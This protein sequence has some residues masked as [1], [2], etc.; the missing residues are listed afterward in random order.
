MPL[1]DVPRGTSFT[2][3]EFN[4]LPRNPD[5][6]LAPLTLEQAD[7]LRKAI[8]LDA[9]AASS[10]TAPAAATQLLGISA[11]HR[12]IDSA[13]A[14]S[15]LSDE[16]K[17]A[18]RSAL[19]IYREQFVPRFKTGL[20]IDILGNTRKNVPR[21][22][23]DNVV[24]KV[25]SNESGVSQ[26]MA[27]FKGDPQANAS[28]K[29]G[30][31]DLFERQL[32]Q[33]PESAQ[34]WLTRH[35]KVFDDLEAQGVDV[36]SGLEQ[37][38]RRFVQQQEN[39]AALASLQTQFGAKNAGELVDTMLQSSA[40]LSRGLKAMDDTGRRAFAQEISDRAMTLVETGNYAGA[41]KFLT[42]KKALIKQ[43]IDSANPGAAN[44]IYDEMLDAANFGKEIDA[45]SKRLPR[46]LKPSAVSLQTNYTPQQLA[47]LQVVADDL[48]RSEI[49]SDM[50]Q[51][52]AQPT[53]PSPGRAATEQ[54]E[55]GGIS[56]ASA[57]TFLSTW[58]SAARVIWKQLELGVNKRT[59]V[60]LAKWMHEDPDAAIAMLQE[61]QDRATRRTGMQSTARK[62]TGAIATGVAAGKATNALA[63]TTNNNA[64]SE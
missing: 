32:A 57:P 37:T 34:T 46:Q 51:F 60:V 56:A 21:L 25:I 61:A 33:S 45:L 1:S 19:Q 22:I 47:D 8:N 9:A 55:A 31:E 2:A 50:A 62:V 18:Y 63:P 49:V 5:G 13:V 40:N 59:A 28:L 44:Q 36:R 38:Q 42:E 3:A 17:S 11:L 26:Y 52:G 48:R 53:R 27:M 64:L 41:I 12:E 10:S 4:K 39:E 7:G 23:P 54:A 24:D 16:A 29:A 15:N 6:T 58:A 14:N 30:I 35:R 43:A 20:Q